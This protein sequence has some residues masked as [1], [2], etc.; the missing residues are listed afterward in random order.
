MDRPRL[1]TYLA[2]LKE[3]REVDERWVEYLGVGPEDPNM[4][5][6]MLESSVRSELWADHDQVESLTELPPPV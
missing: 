4:V 3:E 2:S 6:D 5:E 1:E